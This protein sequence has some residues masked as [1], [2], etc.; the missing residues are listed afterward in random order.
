[1]IRPFTIWGVASAA[2]F[3]AAI[4]SR[5][6]DRS[7]E[8]SAEERGALALG[9]ADGPRLDPHG[10]RIDQ[11]KLSGFDL[12]RLRLAPV[13]ELTR[14]VLDLLATRQIDS[15]L[16]VIASLPVE[17]AVEVLASVAHPARLAGLSPLE[18]DAVARM[19]VANEALLVA[20]TEA[21]PDAVATLVAGA[22]AETSSAILA[23]ITEPGRLAATPLGTLLRLAESLSALADL[24]VRSDFDADQLF[25]TLAIKRFSPGFTDL[26]PES[27]FGVKLRELKAEAKAKGET[28]ELKARISALYREALKAVTDTPRKERNQPHG[29]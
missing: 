6:V 11:G 2:L 5:A 16:A 22:S 26:S 28:P 9:V 24:K 21:S 14:L 27:H 13:S 20:L 8:L 4:S 17:T 7:R 23:A 25:A 19:L 1:M 29:R 15:A 18:V 12:E 10:T 3:V